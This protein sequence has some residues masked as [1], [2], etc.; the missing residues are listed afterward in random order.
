MLKKE[1][2]GEKIHDTFFVKPG[3]SYEECIE[4]KPGMVFDYNY[5]ASDFV[6]FNIHYHAEDEIRFPVKQKG[7]MGGKGTIDPGQHDY[8]TEKLN[9]YCL[10]WDNVNDEKVEISFECVLKKK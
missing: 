10:M 7:R 3:G 4:L 2:G 1:V 9:T 6:N 5:D 8:Y